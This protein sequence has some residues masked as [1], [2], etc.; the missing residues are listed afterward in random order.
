MMNVRNFAMI[1]LLDLNDGSFM[2][3][4][5]VVHRGMES[6]LWIVLPNALRGHPNHFSRLL[7]GALQAPVQS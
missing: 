7:R 6:A 3:N 4:R 2:S 5:N 1:P